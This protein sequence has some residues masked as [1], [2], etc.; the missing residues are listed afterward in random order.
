LTVGA[1]E[2]NLRY[3]DLLVN[4]D[5]LVLLDGCHLLVLTSWYW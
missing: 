3:P 4:P 2:S 1:D 5:A